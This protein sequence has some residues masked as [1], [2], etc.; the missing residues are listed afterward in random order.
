MDELEYVSV[1]L[2]NT[3]RMTLT[4][5]VWVGDIHVYDA[6]SFITLGSYQMDVNA[7]EH[8]L[9]SDLSGEGSTNRVDL[10]SQ[11]VWHSPP[12]GGTVISLR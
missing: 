11:I 2:T 1:S 3:T 7:E 4:T 9:D 12:D 8:H 5:N 10:Y 6:N